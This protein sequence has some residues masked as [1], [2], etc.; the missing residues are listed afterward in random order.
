MNKTQRSDVTK[1]V[2][3]L[4]ETTDRAELA[5]KLAAYLLSV[6][7]SKDAGTILR[8]LESMRLNRDGILEVTATSARPLSPATINSIKALFDAREVI[9]H[10]E[11]D[12]SLLG[13]VQ[14]R[15]HDKKLDFSVRARLQRLRNGR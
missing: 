9:I 11:Q 5:D 1:A 12:P 13:G 6:R 15:A 7:A 2:Y 8:D 4:L 10:Q 3:S 14:V